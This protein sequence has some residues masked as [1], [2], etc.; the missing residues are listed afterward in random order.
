[1]VSG[2]RAPA[3]VI[4]A[5]AAAPSPKQAASWPMEFV[6][7]GFALPAGLLSFYARQPGAAKIDQTLQ[8][9]SR[10]VLD[11][12]VESAALFYDPFATTASV[13]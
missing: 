10:S 3:S 6:L 4:V 5:G 13:T 2:V 12:R 7:D 9:F 8:L 11:L 1:M